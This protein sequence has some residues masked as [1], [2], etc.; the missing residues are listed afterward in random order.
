MNRRYPLEGVDFVYWT[1]GVPKVPTWACHNPGKLLPDITLM[2]WDEQAKLL[3][4]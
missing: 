1:K 3:G 4:S 2:K